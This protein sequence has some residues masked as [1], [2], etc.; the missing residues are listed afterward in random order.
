MPSPSVQQSLRFGY[1]DFAQPRF[2]SRAMQRIARLAVRLVVALGILLSGLNPSLAGANNAAS[3]PAHMSMGMHMG[4]S[5]GMP[6][7]QSPCGGMDCGCCV[8]GSCAAPAM[9][10]ET[11]EISAKWTSDKTDHNCAALRGVTFPPDIRPP[12]SRAI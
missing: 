12:I 2:Y 8:G 6:G 1:L 4:G 5:H 9:V 7:K 3:Q 11:L 10:L